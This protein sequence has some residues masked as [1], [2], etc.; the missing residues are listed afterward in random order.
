MFVKHNI[1]V[2]YI[3]MFYNYYCV[4]T[5][6]LILCISVVNVTDSS[7]N[8]GGI[9]LFVLSTLPLFFGNAIYAF[10][11]IGMVCNM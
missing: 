9:D 11:G 10:E 4:R 5:Y 3:T 1:R 2:T 7:G 8:G 6:V